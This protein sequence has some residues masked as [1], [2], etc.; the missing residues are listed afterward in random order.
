MES[1][2]SEAPTEVDNDGNFSMPASGAGSP[3]EVDPSD[4]DL[5]EAPEAAA[6]DAVSWASGAC[7][8]DDG[9]EAEV[10]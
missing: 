5:K 6:P 10:E 1:V 8:A 3:R 7:A 4:A 9:E 2:L